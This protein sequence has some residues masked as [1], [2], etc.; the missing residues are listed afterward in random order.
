LSKD[1]IKLTA[2]VIVLVVAGWVFFTWGEPT[3]AIKSQ[4]EFV[5]VETGERFAL[6]RANVGAIPATNPDT[7]QATLYPVH[8][9][10][11]KLVVSARYRTAMK[12]SKVNNYVDP[13]T[14][15]V[16]VP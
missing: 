1:T 10:D 3:S 14:L 13:N 2:G 5:C 12:D 8:E 15:E 7:G 16:R 4:I 9:E 11:G 6:N